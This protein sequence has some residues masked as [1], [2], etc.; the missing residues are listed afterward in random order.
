MKVNETNFRNF[1]HQCQLH[2]AESFPARKCLNV[3][4]AVNSALCTFFPAIFIDSHL[5]FK[6]GFL[7]DQ[8]SGLKYPRV[9]TDSVPC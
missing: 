3:L 8:I 5:L 6:E 9:I 4:F 7:L 1:P 2:C